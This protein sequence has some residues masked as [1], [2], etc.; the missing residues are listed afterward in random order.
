MLNNFIIE[1][2]NEN[3]AKEVMNQIDASKKKVIAVLNMEIK[4]LIH[5]KVGTLSGSNFTHTTL[6][7]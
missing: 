7:K 1:N 3:P 2:N 6:S 5:N 4:N